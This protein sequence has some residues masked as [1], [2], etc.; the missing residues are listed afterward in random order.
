L[1]PKIEPVAPKPVAQKKDRRRLR[2]GQWNQQPQTTTPVAASAEVQAQEEENRRLEA[3]REQRTA[4]K[5]LFGRE[6]NEAHI[7]LVSVVLQYDKIFSVSK[8]IWTKKG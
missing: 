3:E 2:F 8:Q 4:V 7:P 1:D 5:S 6:L